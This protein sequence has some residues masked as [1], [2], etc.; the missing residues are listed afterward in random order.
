V[1]GVYFQAEA[2]RLLGNFFG[3]K[4]IFQVEA[5]SVVHRIAEVGLFK[6]KNPY[7]ITD[8]NSRP[9][10]PQSP[11]SAPLLSSS[12]RI[13]I[14]TRRSR[15]ALSVPLR[16]SK[17]ALISGRAVKVPCQA[18]SSSRI[19]RYSNSSCPEQ[20]QGAGMSESQ[21]VVAVMHFDY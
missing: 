21:V 6:F 19:A 12:P 10:Y 20:A 4:G 13:F 16:C 15:F 5:E 1:L 11:P 2:G 8:L 9:L 18:P 3:I 17:P 7:P 14:H